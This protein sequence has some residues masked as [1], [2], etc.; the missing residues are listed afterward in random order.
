MP[1]YI[2]AYHGG[3]APSSP[4]EGERVMAEWVAWFEGMGDAV[5]VMGNPCGQSKTVF[6]SKVSDDGG[7][8]PISGYSVV[9][10]ADHDAACALAKGCPMV[11]DGSGS[12]EVAE[13]MS[14]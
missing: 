1:D 13:L 3:A 10:A 2:L 5:V 12:A 14:M 11:K 7:A 4:E 6:Q 8:N 9:R